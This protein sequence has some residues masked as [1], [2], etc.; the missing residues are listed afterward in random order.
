[1]A[2]LQGVPEPAQRA[3]SETFDR[4]RQIYKVIRRMLEVVGLSCTR[5]DRTLFSGASFVLASGALLHVA[6]T[7][8]SGK[9][10]L[11]RILCGLSA[12]DAGEIRWRDMDIRSLR[13]AYWQNLI[14]IGH[15]N[16]IKDDLSALENLLFSSKLA[17]VGA[18]RETALAALSIFGLAGFEHLPTRML[19]Q[20]QK[21]RTALAQ[22]ALRSDTPLWILD[23]PFSAL[24]VAA[25]RCLEKLILTHIGSGGSVIFTT[26]HEAT[27]AA[28]VTLCV[29]LD[30]M[31]EFAC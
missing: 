29:D 9:T 27:I 14:Y 31:S 24:D 5:G 26:H 2:G 11:L 19:S 17:D 16:A 4:F 12:P 10:S 8:G 20:G 25:V 6:G 22:L 28:Y 15:A 13:E 18:T 1:M 7:N 3:Q 30:A 21:R 23:E